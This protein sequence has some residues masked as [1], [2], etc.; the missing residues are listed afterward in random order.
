MEIDLRGHLVG[1]QGALRIDDGDRGL[2][3]RALNGQDELAT[4]ELSA[5]LRSAGRRLKGPI[6]RH[7]SRRLG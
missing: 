2:V 3:A 7:R 5:L 1:E 6:A 4:L